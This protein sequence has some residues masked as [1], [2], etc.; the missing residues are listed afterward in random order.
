MSQYLNEANRV[1]SEQPK[2]RSELMVSIQIFQNIEV[3]RTDLVPKF[4]RS[5][6]NEPGRESEGEREVKGKD[7]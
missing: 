3:N 1:S 2:K 7:R 5:A 4:A 6:W